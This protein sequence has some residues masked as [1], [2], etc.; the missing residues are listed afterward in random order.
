MV[1][2]IILI[3]GTTPLST[4]SWP[5]AVRRGPA[6]ERSSTPSSLPA[7]TDSDSG[8]SHCAGHPAARHWTALGRGKA[9][10]A[11]LSKTAKCPEPAPPRPFWATPDPTEQHEQDDSGPASLRPLWKPSQGGA[12]CPLQRSPECVVRGQRYRCV[13]AVV[14]SGAEETVAPR[15]AF[16]GQTRASAMSKAGACYRTASGAP[17]ANLGEPDVKFLTNEGYVGEIPFQ[18]ADIERPLIAVSSLAKAGNAVELTQ[19]GGSITHQATGRVTGIERRGGT[20]ALRMWVPA[21]STSSPF[22]RQ[23]TR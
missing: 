13:E 17:V 15:G 12:L 4:P 9:W 21:D 8:G 2:L 14:D 10:G 3:T 7:E 23:G 18:L 22:T 16:P 1:K 11:P 19:D 20:Y 5:V 6:M